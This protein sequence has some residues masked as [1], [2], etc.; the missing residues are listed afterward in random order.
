MTITRTTLTLASA[1]L[2]ALRELD[3][4]LAAWARIIANQPAWYQDT[5][6]PMADLTLTG[7]GVTGYAADQ[8]Q[9]YLVLS[10][11]PEEQA[12]R[13][14]GLGSMSD[15]DVVLVRIDLF[16]AWHNP[17]EVELAV[18]REQS[19]DWLSWASLMRPRTTNPVALAR[20][21]F[22]DA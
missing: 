7:V 4:D 20:S 15:F 10:L 19:R 16:G 12:C 13:L 2:D 11:C 14:A 5:L 21:Y 3:K 17:N 1:E 6:R 22:E 9:T 8:T 18:F